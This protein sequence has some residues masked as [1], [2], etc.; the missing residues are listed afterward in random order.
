MTDTPLRLDR[1]SKK[2]RKG[3][4]Y[5]SLRDLVPAIARRLVRRP[6]PEELADREFWALREVSLSARR[7]EPLGIIGRNG[8]G[9]STILRLLAGIMRPTTGTVTVHG[10]LSALIEI[11]AGFHPDLTGRENVYLNGTILGMKREEIRRKFDAIVEF[12][13]L[14]E[15]IDTP[16]KRY[17]SGMFARLGFSVSAHLDPDILVID[18]VL[19]VGDF[20]FQRKGLEKMMSVARGGA[21]VIFVSHN[22]QAVADLCQRTILLD[23]GRVLAEGPTPEVIRRYLEAGAVGGS[24]ST[25][26]PVWIES[27]AVEGRSRES[28]GLRFASGETVRVTI[29]VRARARVERLAVVLGLF[30]DRR[31]ELFTTSSERLGEPPFTIEPGGV[32]RR[33]FELTLHLAPGTYSL[34]AAL[35]RYDIQKT[36]G[37]FHGARIFV[38][39]DVDV[40]GVVN[41]HPHMLPP[42]KP[43][44]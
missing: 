8:A 24:A 23:H 7:G 30:D 18:E 1:V 4:L 17:S 14:E 31:Y 22:L 19:S 41:L 37:Q 11:G 9:K 21:T 44:G 40:R 32:V 15:F 43:A 34:D 3:E 20:L 5:D 6:S 26:L 25:E 29:E 35:H 42:G 36:Y 28:D 13:G 12:S 2:F 27:M 39:S 16:V 38:H 33:A 10:R